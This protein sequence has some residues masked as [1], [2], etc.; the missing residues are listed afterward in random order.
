MEERR[1]RIIML[2][3]AYAIFGALFLSGTWVLYEWGSSNAYGC[4]NDGIKLTGLKS[5][6]MAMAVTANLFMAMFASYLWLMSILFS[7]SNRTWV[8][9]TRKMLAF[10]I[11]LLLCVLVLTVIGVAL[12][13]YLK[14]SPYWGEFSIAISF[15]LSIVVWGVW[16]TSN[17]AAEEIALEYYHFPLWFKIFIPFPMLKFGGRQQIRERAEKRAKE[18]KR[19]AYQER[20]MLNPN[21][22]ASNRQ[23]RRSTVGALLRRAADSIGRWDFDVS[24]FEGYL[25][26]DWYNDAAELKS[27]GVEVLSKYMPR[28]LAEEV[29]NQLNP[30][31]IIS[32][33]IGTGFFGDEAPQRKVT[34]DIEESD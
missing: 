28:R 9:S 5:V 22:T 19:R 11:T 13:I 1:E 14:F 10:I 24:K 32:S 29:H 30:D 12:G 3:E 20:T 33:S 4:S 15:L 2:A 34:W 8:F 31:N 18:L 26:E 16:C 21:A 6:V 7:G 17:L 27:I 23:K 25:E